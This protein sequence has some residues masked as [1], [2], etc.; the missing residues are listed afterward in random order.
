MLDN[1]KESKSFI[2]LG[3]VLNKKGEVLVIRRR[4]LEKVLMV[5]VYNGP[6]PVENNS[7][8]RLGRNV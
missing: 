8:M 4:V 3:V 6:L 2:N 5:Q 1:N 7:L